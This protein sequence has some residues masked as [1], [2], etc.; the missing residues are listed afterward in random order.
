MSNLLY[1]LLGPLGCVLAMVVC[2]AMMARGRRANAH[3]E[4]GVTDEV[5]ALRAEVARLS[6]ERATPAESGNE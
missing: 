4:P 1:L 2:M 6:A 3:P 5:A